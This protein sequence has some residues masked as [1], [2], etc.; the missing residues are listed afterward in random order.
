MTPEAWA[1]AEVLRP[2]G[3]GN[4]S[5][6]FLDAGGAIPSVQPLGKT[7]K[8][9][10]VLLGRCELV[11][12]DEER[13]LERVTPQGWI[14]RPRQEV[15]RGRRQLRLYL[16]RIVQGAPVGSAAGGCVG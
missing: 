14:Y 11:A 10:K 4:P 6:L 13:L 7:G 16:E 3:M 8:V 15:W 5:P 2:F 9:F 12:F 1:E